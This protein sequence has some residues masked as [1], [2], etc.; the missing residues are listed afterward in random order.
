MKNTLFL[1][2]LILTGLLQPALADD[3]VDK[4]TE[5]T[6][7][8]IESKMDDPGFDESQMELMLGLC[9][10]QATSPLKAQILKEYKL[11]ISK[12][13]DLEKVSKMIGERAVLNCPRFT[14]YVM[15]MVAEEEAGEKGNK[16]ASVSSNTSTP[17][18]T[19]ELVGKVE[20]FECNDIC[21]IELKE[22]TRT[23]TVYL[24][25]KFNGMEL[26]K[27]GT[28][29]QGE[30]VKLKVEETNFYSQDSKGMVPVYVLRSI[31]LQLD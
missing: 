1:L 26:I 21:R 15:N 9:V 20:V 11:D 14:E 12:S 24:T 22:G 23:Y 2:A 19:R 17:V 7:D 25:D 30:T 13:K 31:S 6:C 5:K 16:P 10:L 28:M 27:K 3:A 18:S 8:C 29:L 4:A